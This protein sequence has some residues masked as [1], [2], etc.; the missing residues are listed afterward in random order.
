M[1]MHPS[2]NP[3][4]SCTTQANG[5]VHAGEANTEH[6]LVLHHECLHAQLQFGV[7]SICIMSDVIL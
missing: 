7:V 2:F 3:I 5:W 6:S 1:L 4:T